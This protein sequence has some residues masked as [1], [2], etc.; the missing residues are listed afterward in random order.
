MKKS[1]FLGV[2]I[3]SGITFSMLK[4]AN[5]WS[6]RNN[7]VAKMGSEHAVWVKNIEL[8]EENKKILEE[9]S[10]PDI[11]QLFQR[12]VISGFAYGVTQFLQSEFFR[13][14]IEKMDIGLALFNATKNKHEKIAIMLLDRIQLSLFSKE[15]VALSLIE[16]ARFSL[17]EL[18]SKFLDKDV[19]R[20]VINDS[21]STP[22]YIACQNGHEEVVRLLLAD[23]RVDDLRVDVN[24][25]TNNG[26][27]PLY[28]ASQNGHEEVVRLL[29][30]DPRD[31]DLRVDV[32]KA[33]NI[34]A[35]PLFIACQQGQE[36]VVKL[37]LADPRVEVNKANDSG[38]TPLYIAC[39]NG[40][41]EVVRLLLTDPR[42]DK[43]R[44]DV[45]KAT[46]DGITP[47]YIACQN[48]HEEVVRLLLADLIAEVN[49]ARDTGITPLFIACQNGHEGVVKLL[50]ADPRVEVKKAK[51]NGSTPL[52]IA[53]QQGH[54]GVVRLLLADPRVEVNKAKDT[55]I[56]PLYIA[57]QNGHEEVVRLLLADRRV[58]VNKARDDG[59][60]P[61]EIILKKKQQATESSNYER[62][63]K[64]RK[65]I[66]MF[67]AFTSELLLQR[68]QQNR[69]A[70]A[71]ELLTA[72]NDFMRSK[73][74]HLREMIFVH[75][76]RDNNLRLLLEVFNFYG[77]P[78]LLTVLSRNQEE[79]QEAKKLFAEVMQEYANDKK[80]EIDNDERC[81]I[82]YKEFKEIKDEAK[83]IAI[84]KL[85]CCGYN[86][87]SDCF[88]EWYNNA[89]EVNK[90]VQ[91][92]KPV[93]L[94]DPTQ[95]ALAQAAQA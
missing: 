77:I 18:I 94:Y 84:M 62:L 26:A 49:K 25:A 34:G 29:L 31:D 73:N 91:C 50:L 67:I 87:D 22:L 58:D 46:N 81:F 89:L 61:L 16:A 10:L 60:T 23:P 2:L 64:Y 79:L 39:Q 76:K 90:C 13:K 63:F 33:M 88:F 59:A 48:G 65:I 43:K 14:N 86:L 45:N 35:T 21:G 9:K 47:L 27:T 52:Y 70:Q 6:Q 85:G 37:L 3:Y 32:N 20:N 41:E 11:K 56:T 7:P 42:D 66:A 30:A 71:Q 92:Q 12:N 38:G 78:A 17:L 95:T 82:C 57:C 15:Y 54:E 68:N 40:H 51:D 53:C 69:L 55:G 83:N 36:G 1:I 8:A 19:D 74:D 93:K 28:I 72:Y 24:K 44:V 4:K 5:N 80:I 75:M